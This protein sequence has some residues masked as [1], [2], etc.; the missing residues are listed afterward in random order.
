M[1]LRGI[2]YRKSELDFPWI[3]LGKGM[4]VQS[5]ENSDF[6]RIFCRKFP[7]FHEYLSQLIVKI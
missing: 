2:I 6:L 3:I 4:Y 1:P 5:A 7:L